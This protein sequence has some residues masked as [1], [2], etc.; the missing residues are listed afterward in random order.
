MREAMHYF[1]K[2]YHKDLSRSKKRKS[3]RGNQTSDIDSESGKEPNAKKPVIAAD[4]V[5]Q[6]SS[7]LT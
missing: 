6:D 5:P 2:Q 3:E 1:Q 7:G 4:E